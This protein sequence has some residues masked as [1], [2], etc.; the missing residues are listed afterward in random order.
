MDNKL[1]LP[2]RVIDRIYLHSLEAG[3]VD[4]FDDL[5]LGHFYFAVAR[6]AVGELSVGYCAV[7]II[8][9]EMQGSLDVEHAET[10]L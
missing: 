3:A 2:P 10:E 6:I 5:L 1:K 9:Y 8:V 7:E 4:H